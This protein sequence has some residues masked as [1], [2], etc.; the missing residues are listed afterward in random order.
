MNDDYTAR[1]GDQRTTRRDII[2]LRPENTGATIIGDLTELGG[3]WSDT[4]DA[5][6]ITQTLHMI[7][8]MKAAVS[9]LF[10]LLKRGGTVL[11]TVPGLTPIDHGQDYETWYWSM[12]EVSARRMFS[13]V[14]GAEG[15]KVATYGNVFSAIC[16]LEGLAA[17]ELN[18]EMLYTR[19]RHYPVTIGICAT[20]D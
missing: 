16:F 3:E 12:T 11:A 4:F 14:F 15:T 18:A 9:A 1:F 8:D 7:F 17:E 19:D 20:K 2:D 13:D 5:I 10:R 6:V